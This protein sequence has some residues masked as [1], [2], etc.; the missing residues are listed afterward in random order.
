MIAMKEQPGG[1]ADYLRGGEGIRR[2]LDERHPGTHRSSAL[3]ARRRSGLLI[4]DE[5]IACAES[6]VA[7]SY[8]RNECQ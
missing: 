5:E 8:V 7:I 1:E 6:E 2:G 3:D 4:S